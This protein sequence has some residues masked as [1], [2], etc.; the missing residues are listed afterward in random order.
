MS[1]YPEDWDSRRRRVY[2]R[3]SHQCQKCNAK[4]GPRGDVEL[5]A[6]HIT[7]KSQGGS[8]ELSNLETLCK[9]CHVSAHPHMD[10]PTDSSKSKSST[11]PHNGPGPEWNST[12]G[13][14]QGTNRNTSGGS[15]SSSR[16]N[17]DSKFYSTSNGSSKNTSSNTSRSLSTDT[18]SNTSRS[19]STA[20]VDMKTG[21]AEST[22]HITIR[23]AQNR[24]STDTDIGSYV[25]EDTHTESGVAHSESEATDTESEAA[26]SGGYPLNPIDFVVQFTGDILDILGYIFEYIL[27]FTLDLV[28]LLIKLLGFTPFLMISCVV[29]FIPAGA[30]AILIEP[31]IKPIFGPSSETSALLIGAMGMFIL[32]GLMVLSIDGSESVGSETADRLWLLGGLN[33]L[34]LIAL[35]IWCIYIIII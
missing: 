17:T 23:R 10:A 15:S 34:I 16:S 14:S 21:S 2:R 19:V 22:E 25:T 9:S 1:G 20:Y 35:I 4:G 5:H 6:H 32:N 31:L 3:D 11:M 7:P 12:K 29:T 26:N 28:V 24:E 30:I 8:H 18:S 27:I 13:L 33:A